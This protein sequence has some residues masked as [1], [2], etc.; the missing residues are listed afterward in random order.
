MLSRFIFYC[1]LA[2]FAWR[3]VRWLLTPSSSR[4]NRSG[5]AGRA[6]AMVRCETCGMFITETSALVAGGRDFCSRHCLEQRARR[7]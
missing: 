6:A 2:Y 1:V 3:F 7:A 5:R 4:P